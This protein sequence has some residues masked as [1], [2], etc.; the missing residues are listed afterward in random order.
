MA[1]TEE[2]KS[3]Q[4]RRVLFIY[5]LFLRNIKLTINEVLDEINKEFG[6]VS[7]RSVQR[8][9]QVLKD[10][11]YIQSE[12]KGR[13]SFWRLNRG[14]KIT[15]PTQI[16]TSEL[17]SF[18]ILKAYLKT[19]KGTAIEEDINNLTKKL[20][21]LAPG[22]AILEETIYWDQNPG[23][24]NYRDKNQLI[25]K[26][27]HFIH[28]KTWVKMEYE[29]MWEEGTVRSYDILPESL[30]TYGGT[31]YLIGYLPKHKAFLNFAVQ[32]II[33]LEESSYQ[34]R[35]YPEFDYEKFRN[36]RFAVMDGELSDV[37][38]KIKKD[39]VIY[40]ENRTWH[41]SQKATTDKSGNMILRL[42]V[43]IQPD[44]ISWILRW[45]EAITVISPE[46]LKQRLKKIYEEAIKWY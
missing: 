19:F 15:L 1:Y 8:D 2:N 44:F 28:E 11:D 34:S 31:I 17:L 29:K 27:L 37:V 35:K 22:D 39:F 36:A 3:E 7:K 30:F 16:K 14:K 12:N 45:T 4:A 38:L 18:Y 40:F 32:N 26:L 20:E 10:S 46:S 21:T 13:N 41:P 6:D 25:S 23:Y 5:S 42:K 43:P 24:Y 33:N 9:L